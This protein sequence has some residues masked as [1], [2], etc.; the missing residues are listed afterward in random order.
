VAVARAG[1][2]RRGSVR[3]PVAGRARSRV[4]REDVGDGSAAEGGGAHGL[5]GEGCGEQPLACTEDDRVNDEAV[6]VD[7][8]GLDERSSEPDV[9]EFENTTLGI[10]F[11]GAANGP[12]A[13]GQ[14][15]AQRA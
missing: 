15:P 1:S 5:D 2:P 10:S 9:S 7:Q 13:P 3:S 11:I 4:R 12:D 8:P 6:L 14:K